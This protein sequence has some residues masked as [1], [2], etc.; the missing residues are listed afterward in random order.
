M[1]EWWNIVILAKNQ[2]L[3]AQEG[4]ILFLLPFPIHSHVDTLTQDKSK[5]KNNNNKNKNHRFLC[6]E[7]V[8][9]KNL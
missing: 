3:E 6:D 9:N 4:L 5:K 1:G 7:M 8:I 2:F